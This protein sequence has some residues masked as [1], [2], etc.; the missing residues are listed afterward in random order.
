MV[1]SRLLGAVA[2]AVTLAGL[3]VI[4]DA[5]DARATTITVN[6]ELDIAPNG[7]G[8]FPNDGLCSLRAA[9]RA[10]Q[11]NGNSHDVNCS[12]GLGNNVLDIIQISGALTGK[13]M[14]LTVH[15][16][17]D[18]ISDPANP[19]KIIGPTTLSSGFT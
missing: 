11:N 6:T 9:I 15:Q 2:T 18:T 13:T 14:H 3:L 1:R 7:N 5:P 8:A 16:P 10:A 12:T 19:V 17:F 4:F